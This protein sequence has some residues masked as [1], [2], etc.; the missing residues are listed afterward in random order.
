MLASYKEYPIGH[1]AFLMPKDRIVYKD[2]LEMLKQK[3]TE[4][5]QTIVKMG[6]I[7]NKG[8]RACCSI[9]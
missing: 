2:L 6:G 8:K 5:D 9:F 1:C 7:Y 3:N 4:G